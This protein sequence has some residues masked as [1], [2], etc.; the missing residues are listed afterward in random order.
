MKSIPVDPASI[1]DHRY[2][3]Y[4]VA[5]T[6]GNRYS[7]CLVIAFQDLFTKWHAAPDQKAVRIA[8]LSS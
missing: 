1:S 3:H 4:G 2:K 6:G 5:N 7:I 8:K